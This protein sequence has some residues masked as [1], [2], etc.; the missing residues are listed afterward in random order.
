MLPDRSDADDALGGA[1]GALFLRRSGLTNEQLRE[2]WRLASGGTSKQ[3]LERHDWFVACKLVAATQ[4]K[5]V[6][7]SMMAVVGTE[8]LPL[9]DFHYDADPDVEVTT[10]A[11]SGTAA[12]GEE[13]PV[14]ARARRKGG[15]G[16][17]A[18]ACGAAHSHASATMSTRIVLC[19]RQHRVPTAPPRRSPPRCA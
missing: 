4:S 1:E 2:V 17:R 18:T 6:E 15:K 19:G 11:P 16:G 3:K 9:A 13:V 7:P 8:P 10:G 14:G 5:G 12:S